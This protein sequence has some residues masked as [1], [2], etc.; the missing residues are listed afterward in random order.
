MKILVVYD[1]ASGNT[2]QIARAMGKALETRHSVNVLRTGA[3]SPQQLQAVNLLIAGSPTYG[4]RPT[5]EMLK[6]LNNIPEGSL[7]QMD[8]AAFDTRLTTALVKLFG[9]AAGKIAGQLKDKGGNQVAAPEGF[10]VKG[11]KGPLKEGEL[12]RAAEWAAGIVAGQKTRVL[13]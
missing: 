3:V 8:V 5:P 2:E 13:S 7:K 1:S 6:F 11:G 9:Y 4:G 12:E 10:F